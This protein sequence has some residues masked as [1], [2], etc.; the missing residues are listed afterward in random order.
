MNGSTAEADGHFHES[1]EMS[2]FNLAFET[3]SDSCHIE[4]DSD[5]SLSEMALE[6]VNGHGI[7]ITLN[8]STTLFTGYDDG[9]SLEG[10]GGHMTQQDL[11]SR[12]TVQRRNSSLDQLNSSS[13]ENNG[14]VV[15]K[16]IVTIG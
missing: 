1:A 15:T 13:V 4:L 5:K 8:N 6:P 7:V 11:K 12:D 3:N 2:E 9:E 16:A 14:V 10:T